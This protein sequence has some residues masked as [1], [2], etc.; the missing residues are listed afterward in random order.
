[1]LFA[2]VPFPVT[3]KLSVMI[4]SAMDVDSFIILILESVNECRQVNHLQAKTFRIYF[5]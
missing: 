2:L 1:M 5:L 4:E 3:K